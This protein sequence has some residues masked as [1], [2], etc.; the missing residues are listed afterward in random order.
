M[1]IKT[2]KKI[3]IPI[4]VTLAIIISAI[5]IIR[6]TGQEDIELS[7][8]SLKSDTCY[9][10]ENISWGMSVDEVNKLLPYKLQ[11]DTAKEPLPANIAFYKSKAKYI[12][13]NQI[14]Y[15]SFEFYN[16]ELKIIKF[17]FHLNE[18]YNQWFEQL[19]KKLI[20]MY[21]TETEKLENS[22]EKL[23]SLGYR[24]DTNNTTL[25]LVLMTGDSINPSATL[26]VGIK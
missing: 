2:S 14:S 19:T 9:Q 8:T 11:K 1:K 4:I 25:Q 17:D 20:E 12:L 7:L 26:G 6:S 24:W 18:N 23:Q 13:D 21:G 22:S 15:A 16:N 3:I 5:F 10:F